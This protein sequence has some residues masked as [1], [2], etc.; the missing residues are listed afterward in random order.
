VKQLDARLS[1]L[2]AAQAA[3]LERDPVADWLA[4][5]RRGDPVDARNAGAG[6]AWVAM[7]IQRN[8][9]AEETIAT[10]EQDDD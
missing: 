6:P 7:A 1:K 10:Y 8:T 9:E 4:S 3:T 2:E 5:F